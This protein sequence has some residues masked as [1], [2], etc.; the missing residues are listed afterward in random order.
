MSIRIGHSYIKNARGNQCDYALHFLL[1]ILEWRE[2]KGD[3]A[4]PFVISYEEME[5]RNP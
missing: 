5:F 2:F 3:R 4:I 1:M